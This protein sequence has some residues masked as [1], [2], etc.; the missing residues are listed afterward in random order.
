DLGGDEKR[1][2][3]VGARQRASSTDLPRLSERS[4]RRSRSEFCGTTPARAS[5]WSRRA[6]STA[7]E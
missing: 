3:G 5:Q 7:A 4:D 6:A 2:A 1:S